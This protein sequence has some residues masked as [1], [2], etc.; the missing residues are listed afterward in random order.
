VRDVVARHNMIF[1]SPDYRA[2]A[3][4]MGAAAEADTLQLLVELK[5][6]FKVRKK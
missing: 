1:V 5:R 6:Q 2:P 3:G 4:W